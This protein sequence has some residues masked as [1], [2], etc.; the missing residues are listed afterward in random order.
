MHAVSSCV[1]E[2]DKFYAILNCALNESLQQRRG[3]FAAR[4]ANAKTTFRRQQRALARR[5]Y[6]F[7]DDESPGGQSGLTENNFPKIFA[8][9]ETRSHAP[10]NFGAL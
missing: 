7:G 1:L 10:L 8:K 5:T 2:Q 6:L 4:T 9:G 3:I